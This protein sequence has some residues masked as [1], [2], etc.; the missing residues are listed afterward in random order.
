MKKRFEAVLHLS[1]PRSASDILA[2]ANRV[3]KGLS[4]NTSVFA[5][6]D[7]AIAVLQAETALL[8]QLMTESANGDR[9]KIQARNEQAEKLNDL[10]KHLA[11]YVTKVAAFDRA[12]ILLS[13]FD[14]SA[15]PKPVPGPDKVSITRIV[16]G[17]LPLSARIL[18]MSPGVR[19]TFRLQISTTP[20]D[21]KSWTLILETD[22]SRKLIAEN[23]ERGKE[24]FF[25]VAARNHR[26]N[27]GWSESVGFICR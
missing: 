19:A 4:E 18:V 1:T 7:P 3:I 22:N 16:D 20:E 27:S 14:A 23:L 25:R 9:Q 21:E 24:F 6:P 11:A 26:G 5:N 17:P 12:A 10:L 2:L 8:Q 13:G 15:E